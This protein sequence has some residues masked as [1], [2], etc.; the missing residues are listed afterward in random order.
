MLNNLVASPDGNLNVL[1]KVSPKTF[2]TSP[3]AHSQTQRS[4]TGALD[5]FPSNSWF[6][7]KL[8]RKPNE[9]DRTREYTNSVI[10]PGSCRDSRG[11][12]GLPVPR[13]WVAVVE[14]EVEEAT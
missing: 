3:K 12:S 4:P 6:E 9:S 7:Q 11:R 1:P 5:Y 2:P 8:L 10:C 14:E 13:S